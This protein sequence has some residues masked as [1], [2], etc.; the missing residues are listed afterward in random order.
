MGGQQ[1][2]VPGSRG[3]PSARSSMSKRMG[4]GEPKENAAGFLLLGPDLT[5]TQG[6]SFHRRE[7]RGSEREKALPKVTW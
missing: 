4:G 7:Q 3:G 6:T 5:L 2:G 1:A